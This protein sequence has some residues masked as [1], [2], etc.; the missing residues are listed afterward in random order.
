MVHYDLRKEP[1]GPHRGGSFNRHDIGSEAENFRAHKG[2]LYGFVQIGH[3]KA[4]KL[5][6]VAAGGD[7]QRRDNVL[8]LLFATPEQGGQRLIGWYDNAACHAAY[9]DRPR[10]HGVYN[11]ETRASDAVLLP[12]PYRTFEAPD[13][14]SG[15]FG[16][17]HVRYARSANG[18]CAQL[19][20]MSA[21]VEW[22][23]SYRGP[24]LLEGRTLEPS[25]KA[26]HRRTTPRPTMR[27]ADLPT[28][29]PDVP[30]RCAR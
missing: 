24:N 18:Q 12:L 27:R 19:G 6:R 21:A 15:G 29:K 10:A 22:I 3:D 4:F 7:T 25:T 1:D 5:K 2:K 14:Y 20:W 9:K 17:S 11:F 23:R 13:R 8:V 26:T 16:Q 30:W 28:L